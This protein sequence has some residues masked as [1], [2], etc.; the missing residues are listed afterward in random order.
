[1][2]ETFVISGIFALLAAYSYAVTDG[3]IISARDNAIA[4]AGK[5]IFSN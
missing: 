5:G 4:V 1:L 2:P 3:K